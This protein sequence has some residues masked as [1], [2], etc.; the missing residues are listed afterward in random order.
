[1]HTWRDLQPMSSA[2]CKRSP[3]RCTAKSGT[4]RPAAS[5]SRYMSTLPQR[6]LSQYSSLR[7]ILC[8]CPVQVG[9]FHLE[10]LLIGALSSQMSKVS[11]S[12]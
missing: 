2:A 4:A 5:A 1:M 3:S 12:H 7:H 8:F 10:I 9:R 6:L 11:I